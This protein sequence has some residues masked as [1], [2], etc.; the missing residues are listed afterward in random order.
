MEKNFIGIVL[1]GGHATRLRPCTNVTNKHLLPVYNQPMIYYPIQTLVK[2]QVKDIMIVTG[3]D[4]E[5]SFRELFRNNPDFSGINFQFA[6]QKEAGGIAQALALAREF[7][8]NRPIIVILG[9]NVF[10]DDITGAV[11]SFLKQEK[12]A[13]LFLKEVP[14]PERFG[15]AEIKDDKIVSIEEKPMAPKS[16]LAVTGLYMYDTDVW[17]AID[18]LKPSARGE[19]EITDVNNWFSKNSIVTFD[20]ITGDWTDAGTFRSLLRA[21]LIA[22]KKA[23]SDVKEVIKEVFGK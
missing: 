21:N 4:H 9:D 19:L 22:A 11:M 12:G 2:A 10:E 14:D 8:G 1:A 20:V 23:G 18:T 7:A 17:K 15:V 5:N 6:I 3:T 13:K 16:N